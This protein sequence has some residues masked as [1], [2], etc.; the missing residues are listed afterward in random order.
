MVACNFNIQLTFVWAGWENSAYDTC[1]FL[2]AINNIN[3]KFSKPLKGSYLRK[4][5]C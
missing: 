5:E 4:I 1:I 3:I 2:E